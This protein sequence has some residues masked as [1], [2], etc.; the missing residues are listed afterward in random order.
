MEEQKNKTT[1]AVI[2]LEGG[3]VQETFCDSPLEVIV[4]DLD[5]H[6][7]ERWVCSRAASSRLSEM[8]KELRGQYQKFVKRSRGAEGR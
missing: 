6:S 7:K 8:P 1:R 2:F 5:A 3:L 4:M